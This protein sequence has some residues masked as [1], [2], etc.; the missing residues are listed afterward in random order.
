MGSSII[1]GG[2]IS[3]NGIQFTDIRTQYV[4]NTIVGSVSVIGGILGASRVSS[5]T[6]SVFKSNSISSEVRKAHKNNHFLT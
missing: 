4:A 1:T 3:G 5:F 2:I 6:N